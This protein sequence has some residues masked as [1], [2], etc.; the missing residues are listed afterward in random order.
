MMH[1]LLRRVLPRG[2]LENILGDKYEDYLEIDR[3]LKFFEEY[4]TDIIEMIGLLKFFEVNNR[5]EEDEGFNPD[6]EDL[7]HKLEEILHNGEKVKEGEE[8]D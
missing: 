7:L 1:E 4:G 8:T 6:W 3:R 2:N 5:F